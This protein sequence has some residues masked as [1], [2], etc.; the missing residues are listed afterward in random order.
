[1]VSKK[2]KLVNVIQVMLF[3]RVLPCQRRAYNLW[4]F[5]PAT[6]QMLKELFD[7]THEDI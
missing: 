6:H 3:R 1:M 2:I 7:S 4:E 5:D